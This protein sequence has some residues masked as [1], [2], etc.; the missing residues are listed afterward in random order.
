[1]TIR[2]LPD[3]LEPGFHCVRTR[4]IRGFMTFQRA[5]L[6]QPLV[7]DAARRARVQATTADAHEQGCPAGRGGERRAPGVQ[8][9]GY[10][11]ER[12][13]ADRHGSFLV[14]LAPDPDSAATLVEV[15]GVQP[16]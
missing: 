7:H 12:G 4:W 5:R 6:A 11:A 9:P 15:A 1:M 8:P 10:R 14:A 3:A 2:L 16:A 13:H